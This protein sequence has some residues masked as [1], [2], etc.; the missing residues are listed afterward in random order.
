MLRWRD[1]RLAEQRERLNEARLRQR[2]ADKE[3]EELRAR[4]GEL[5]DLRARVGDLRQEYRSL[6]AEVRTWKERAARVVSPSWLSTVHSIRRVYYAAGLTPGADT[7]PTRRVNQKLANYRLAASHG[8]PV[9][10]VHRY[11]E[12]PEEIDLEDLPSRCV[13]KADRGASSEAVILLRRDGDAFLDTKGRRVTTESVIQKFRRIADRNRCEGPYFA[14]EWLEDS[15]GRE[16][17]L[18]I[19]VYAFYGEIGHVLLRAPVQH[20]GRQHPRRYLDEHGTDLFGDGPEAFASPPR[21]LQAVD[22]ARRLSLIVPFPFVRVDLYDTPRGLVFGEFT[23]APGGPQE[24]DP[25]HD[26]C[27]GQLYD[28]ARA[29]L[30]HDLSHDR[31]YAFVYGDADVSGAPEAW[32]CHRRLEQSWAAPAV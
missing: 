24:Y 30:H 31:P 9:P 4:L 13:L 11:W 7:L 23:L 12:T 8:V 19:K 21:L 28:S 5:N 1:E 20:I 15:T 22:L 17:P 27:L 2:R 32:H 29:R 16:I 14:E 18:D 25:D 6:E 3:L 10:A 26:R